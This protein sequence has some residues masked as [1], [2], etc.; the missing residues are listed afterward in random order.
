M[1]CLKL[2]GVTYL[3]SLG[4]PSIYEFMNEWTFPKSLSLTGR[5]VA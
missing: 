1:R 4:C 3:T 2:K 5:V